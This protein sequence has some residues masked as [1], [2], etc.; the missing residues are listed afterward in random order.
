MK[1]F[2]ACAAALLIT[3]ALTTTSFAIAGFGLHW[4]NDLTLQM[5]DVDKEWLSFGELS[6]DTSGLDLG[7]LPSGMSGISGKDLPIYLTRTDWQRTNFNVGG[8]VYIDIIPML[9]ALELS[10]NFGLWQ[11]EGSISYPTSV[12]LKSGVNYANVKSPEDLYTVS[13]KT[14][15]LTLDAYDMGFFGITGTPYMKLG[16]D[17]TVRK[18]LFKFPPVVNVLRIYGGGGMSLNFATPV[19]HRSIIEDALGT[20]LEDAFSLDQLDA[21]LFSNEE[22]MKKVL[23]EILGNMMTPHMGCHLDLGAMIKIPVIP[24]GIYVDGKFMLP[25]DKMDENVDLGGMGLVVNTGVSL[26]F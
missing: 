11:Y 23:E 12:A 10:A 15:K 7:G 20:T 3:C 13:Y 6:I 22:M 5:E 24:I 2:K 21:D 25:F 18:Y 1:C 17:L 19:L 9:D 26:S 16:F 8:K 14:E 4:G